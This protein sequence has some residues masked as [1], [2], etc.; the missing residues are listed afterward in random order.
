MLIAQQNHEHKEE[1]PN[2]SRRTLA[3]TTAVHQVRCIHVPAIELVTVAVA[4]TVSQLAKS[5][6]VDTDRPAWSPNAL[7][8]LAPVR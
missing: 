8:E 7:V 6:S 5:E 2:L 1:P 3:L 4:A